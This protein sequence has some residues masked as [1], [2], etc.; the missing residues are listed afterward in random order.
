[1]NQNNDGGHET[2][3]KRVLEKHN[4]RHLR[5]CVNT[6]GHR[7][8]FNVQVFLGPILAP[9]HSDEQRCA[10][11]RDHQTRDGEA[12]PRPAVGPRVFVF[13]A[14]PFSISVVYAN[15]R[16]PALVTQAV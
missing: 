5:D 12:E 10:Y 11:E 6:G 9:A 14:P 4:F 8:I 2:P 3:P 13:Q 16:A 15:V 1:M 7:R